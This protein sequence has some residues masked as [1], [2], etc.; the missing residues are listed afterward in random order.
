VVKE[1][2][3]QHINHVAVICIGHGLSVLASMFVAQAGR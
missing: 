2:C 3:M 1:Q